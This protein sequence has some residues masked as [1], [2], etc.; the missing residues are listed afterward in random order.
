MSPK[1]SASSNART[2]VNSDFTTAALIVWSLL[3]LWLCWLEGVS[4]HDYRAYLRQWRLLLDGS[5]PWSTDN[6]YGPV[7]TLIGFLLPYGTLAPKLFMVG[8]LL[9]ANAALVFILLRER[10]INPILII[11][12]LAVPTNLLVVGAGVIYGDNDVL[13][14][15][16]LVPAVLLRTRGSFVA[17]GALIG[18]AALLKY[19]PLLLLPF[20]ALNERRLH[21]SVIITGLA[22]FCVG[23][24][25]AFAIWGEGRLFH[26]ITY[27][28][29]R[30]TKLLSILRPLEELLG[31]AGIVHWLKKYNAYFV[32][33]G[34]AV[35]FMSSWRAGRNWLE[36]AVLGYLVMLTLYKIGNQQFY[37]P[38]LF[39]VAALPL[40]HKQSADRMAI[41]FLPAVLLLSLYQFG[42]QFGSDPY[43]IHEFGWVRSYGGLI[44]FAVSAASIAACV[45]DH[46]RH[47]PIVELQRP[48]IK[49]VETPISGG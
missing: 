1:T 15:A 10:G 2:G 40:V 45:I 25:A 18:I 38:W 42:Y 7:H 22:V 49:S 17:T 47:D 11:Y 14:A 34:V 16:L 6:A 23:M 35:V 33:S 13:V 19:Y 39:M 36:A 37:I 30:G 44:A 4:R 12:L 24:A 26:G 8:A 5:D 32:V 29:S 41:I 48:T 27:G 3:M 28:V 20:F 21:W 46:R 31:K 43:Y 9:L